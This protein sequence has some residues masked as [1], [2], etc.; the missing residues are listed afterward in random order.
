MTDKERILMM[1]LARLTR[2][3]LCGRCGGYEKEQGLPYVSS[4]EP[5]AGDLVICQGSWVRGVHDWVVGYVDEVKGYGHCMIREIGTDR[6]CDISNESFCTIH[7]IDG[8]HLLTGDQHLF[9]RKVLRAFARGDEYSYRYGGVEFNGR[10]VTIW[11]REVFGGRLHGSDTGSKP[12]HV[13]MRW[14]K[15]SSIKSILLAMRGAGYGTRDFEREVAN[16]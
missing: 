3:R 9:Q 2:P 6:L 14:R 1:L 4:G 12:F 7:N 15:N 8:D 13:A 11:V 5:K 16:A 10:G